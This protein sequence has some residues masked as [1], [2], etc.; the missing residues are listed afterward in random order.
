MVLAMKRIDVLLL[1]LLA[2]IGWGC[3]FALIGLGL[4]APA[5][6]PLP[7][8]ALY[9]GFGA[10][11]GAACTGLRLIVEQQL[12]VSLAGALRRPAADEAA[13]VLP[14]RGFAASAFGA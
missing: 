4:H 3:V 8:A 5:R 11:A 14:A 6:A 9:A 12:P 13:R 1:L 2:A 7:L 10:V